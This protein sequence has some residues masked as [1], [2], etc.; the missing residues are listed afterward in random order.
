[1]NRER[2][3]VTLHIGDGFP[4]V[5]NKPDRNAKCKCGSGKKQKYCCG[6]RTT[7]YST[8]PKEKEPE[9]VEG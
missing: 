3:N 6:D 2:R 1:M 8:K 4:I 9:K 7:F 5:T